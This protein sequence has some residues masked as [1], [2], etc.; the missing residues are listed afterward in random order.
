ML[1]TLEDA[2]MY[3]VTLVQF[4]LRQSAAPAL[5]TAIAGKEYAEMRR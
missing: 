5:Y 3:S 1:M 4:M 2:E